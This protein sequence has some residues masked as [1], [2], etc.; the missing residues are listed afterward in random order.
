MAVTYRRYRYGSV[1]EGEHPSLDDALSAASNDYENNLAAP[2][3]IV[4][5]SE[6]WDRARILD[7]IDPV[8]TEGDEA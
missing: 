8:E 5:D 3:C 2:D 6:M 4:L 1:V 7:H